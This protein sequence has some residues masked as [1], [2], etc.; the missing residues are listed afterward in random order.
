MALI[1][2]PF[3]GKQVSDKAVNCPHCGKYIF[4]TETSTKLFGFHAKWI[5]APLIVC[6]LWGLYFAGIFPFNFFFHEWW[7]SG[8][9]VTYTHIGLSVS[10]V[11]LAFSLVFLEANHVRIAVKILFSSVVALSLTMLAFKIE[12]ECNPKED[13]HQLAKGWYYEQRKDFDN[14]LVWY[15]NAAYNGNSEACCHVA[16]FYDFGYGVK[17]N[18]ETALLWYQ[19]LMQCDYPDSYAVA[20]AYNNIG[21]FYQKGNGVEK[22]LQKAMDFFQMALK[23]VKENGSGEIVR[24]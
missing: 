17:Q 6:V 23:T 9:F 11:L 22:D 20:L 18:Y 15:Q 16:V 8:D 14:A 12:E 2:C 21:V 1:N 10:S 19:K 4:K 3:C 13:Y 24:G 7:D 5:I